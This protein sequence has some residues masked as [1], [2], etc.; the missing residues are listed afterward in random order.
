MVTFDPIANQNAIKPSRAQL[1]KAI[2][3]GNVHLLSP[4]EFHK[5]ERVEDGADETL[6]TIEEIF[7]SSLGEKLTITPDSDYFVDLGG[8]SMGYISLLLS[9]EKAFDIH[10]DLEK[11]NNLRTPMAFYKKIKDKQ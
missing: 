1:K 7:L 3:D 10:F 9:L 2:K 6:K 4:K 5:P 11:D 8:D